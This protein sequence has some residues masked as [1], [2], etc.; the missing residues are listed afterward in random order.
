MIPGINS[1]EGAASGVFWAIVVPIFLVLNFFF[2]MF[3]L[4]W[5]SFPLNI[6]LAAIVPVAVFVIF[7][8][9]CLERFVNWWNLVI[10]ESDFVWDVETGIK[11]YMDLI[12]KKKKEDA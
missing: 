12:N 7:I 4:I 1:L 9:I 11:E 8:K 2:T 6:I 5:F 10:G 3:M